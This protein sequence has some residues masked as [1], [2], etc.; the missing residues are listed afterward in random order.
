MSEIDDLINSHWQGSTKAAQ[1][2][3]AVSKQAISKWRK[4]GIPAM[5]RYHIAAVIS[6][7]GNESPDSPTERPESLP[8]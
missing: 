3:L 2:A 1:A 5:R 6:A 8:G 4:H 7:S